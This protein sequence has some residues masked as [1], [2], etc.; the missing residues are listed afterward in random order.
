MM[1]ANDI[2]KI[3]PEYNNTVIGFNNSGVVLKNR[4]EKD[5]VDL[6]IMARNSKDPSLLKLFESL[7]DLHT[8]KFQKLKLFENKV[9]NEIT[10]G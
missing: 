9:K 1:P 2:V 3:R 5:L 8:L 6:A 7:P 10:N 4:S